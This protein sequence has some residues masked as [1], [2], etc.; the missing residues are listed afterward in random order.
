MMMALPG[1]E[2]DGPSLGSED[3]KSIG[4]PLPLE[5]KH[6]VW[7]RTGTISLVE[8]NA[9]TTEPRMQIWHVEMWIIAIIKSDCKKKFTTRKTWWITV[10]LLNNSGAESHNEDMTW[11]L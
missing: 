3:L 2:R 8:R 11:E 5:Q 10:W 4:A 7:I 9:L 6:T 1:W